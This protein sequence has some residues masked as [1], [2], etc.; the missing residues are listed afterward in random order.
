[1]A[2]VLSYWNGSDEACRVDV[3]SQV[4]ASNGSV[5]S[6]GNGAASRR[7]RAAGPACQA[8]GA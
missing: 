6:R 8:R 3:D 1:M 7:I 5:N 4:A 2:F